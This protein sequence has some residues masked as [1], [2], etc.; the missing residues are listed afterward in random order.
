M[1]SVRESEALYRIA[2]NRERKYRQIIKDLLWMAIRYADGRHTYAP[3]MVR[4]AFKTFKE[5]CPGYTLQ[6]DKTIKKPT[7][8]ELNG[9]FACQGDYLWDLFEEK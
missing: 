2:T 1:E 7:N 6:P 4:E 9:I 3:T 8:K 5:L